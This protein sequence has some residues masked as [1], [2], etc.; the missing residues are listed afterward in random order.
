MF[1]SYVSLPEGIIVT[2]TYIYVW[3]FPIIYIYISPKSSIN[4][5]IFPYKPSILGMLLGISRVAGCLYRCQTALKSK[6]GNKKMS[7]PHIFYDFPYILCKTPHIFSKANIFITWEPSHAR[8]FPQ[9]DSTHPADASV[10]QRTDA[11]TT[12]KHT[13]NRGHNDSTYY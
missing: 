12:Q 5:C 2:H 7:I 11:G 8:R 6:G 10:P 1:Y 13:T 4:R 9:C 3:E